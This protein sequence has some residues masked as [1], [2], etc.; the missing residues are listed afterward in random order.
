MYDSLNR[1][2][3]FVFVNILIL[4]R[5]LWTCVEENRIVA[6][7]LS[8]VTTTELTIKSKLKISFQIRS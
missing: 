1:I 8:T 5:F 4:F 3:V 7:F 2:I 6:F